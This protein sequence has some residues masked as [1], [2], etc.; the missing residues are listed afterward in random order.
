MQHAPAPPYYSW[1]YAYVVG[2][3][4]RVGATRVPLTVQGQW[5]LSRSSFV[6]LPQFMPLTILHDP[7]GGCSHAS[8]ARGTTFSGSLSLS[9]ADSAS[10]AATI[11]LNAGV[12]TKL[13]ASTLLAPM[14]VG[15][16]GG[17]SAA[18]SI[19]ATMSRSTTKGDSVSW[20]D[21]LSIQVHMD[22]AITTSGHARLFVP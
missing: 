18:A 17:G 19:S 2:P 10:N 13:E 8:L 5:T 22:T 15:L 21:S 16:A 7:P 9:R 11:G 20:S 12:S 3:Y 4:G 6:D 1:L 14:G